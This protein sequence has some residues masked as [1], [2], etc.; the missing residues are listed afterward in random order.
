[1]KNMFGFPFVC[2]FFL[3]KHKKTQFK[4]Q[5]RVFREHIYSVLCVFKNRSQEQFSKT[6]TIDVL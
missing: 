5:R 6:K 3:E 2:F 1:M 4:E